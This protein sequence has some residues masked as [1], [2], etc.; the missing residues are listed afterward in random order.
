MGTRALATLV[1]WSCFVLSTGAPVGAETGG[2]VE[3]EP[4]VNR[5]ISDPFRVPETPFGSGNRGLE[6]DTEPGDIIRSVAGGEVVFAGLV[7]GNRHI[8]VLHPDGLR[9]SY[10]MV[11]TIDVLVG[12]RVVQGQAIATAG[13]WF[14][15]GIRD[16]ST[17]LDPALLFNRVLEIPRLVDFEKARGP[18][19]L[20]QAGLFSLSVLEGWMTLPS[21]AAMSLFGGTPVGGAIHLFLE[22]SRGALISGAVLG[23]VDWASTQLDCTSGGTPVPAPSRRRVVVLVGG[24]G[25]SAG[26]ASVSEVDTGALGVADEDVLA[27]SY[28][29]GRLPSAFGDDRGPTPDSALGNI[30]ATE[31]EPADTVASIDDSAA[32]LARL[33]SEARA[34][35]PDA[36]IHVV[37][38]SLGGVVSMKALQL[39]AVDAPAGGSGVT[40]VVTLGSPLAG[41]DAATAVGMLRSSRTGQVVAGVAFDTLGIP[42]GPAIGQLIEGSPT[43][44]GID[45]PVA[46]VQVTSV[47]ARFDPVVPATATRVSGADTVTLPGTPSPA[48]SHGDLP[49]QAT[50]EIGLAQAGLP[51]SCSGV[52][53]GFLDAAIPELI[54]TGEDVVGALAAGLAAQNDQTLGP[55]LDIVGSSRGNWPLPVAP[56]PPATGG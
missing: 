47:A 31:Y 25:S 29:G 24:L 51:P 42:D 43:L 17:Y 50:R 37:A 26:D 41:A 12:Q 13:E 10:S 39:L 20:E 52:V 28:A 49:A 46:G 8:T 45:D 55:S 54:S 36:E 19:L 11:A 3:Y 16:G 53:D 35:A 6:Y 23:F 33:L 38:H 44:R 15:L 21:D 34:A 9:S 30:A 48:G 56:P 2:A 27:F 7:A 1:V 22:L 32:A 14:H 40:S 18:S 5:P 4:P